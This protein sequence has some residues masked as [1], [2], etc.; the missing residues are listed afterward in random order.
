LL[1]AVAELRDQAGFTFV[2]CSPPL[3]LGMTDQAAY[4]HA[5]QVPRDGHP[6]RF[7]HAV[8]GQA[9]ATAL[10]GRLDPGGPDASTVAG[11]RPAA[12]R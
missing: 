12:H 4:A 1:A 5:W 9:V 6:N 2:D 7:M 11:P 8:M 3:F 10:R